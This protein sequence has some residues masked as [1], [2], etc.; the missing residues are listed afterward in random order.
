MHQ[1]AWDQIEALYS[2]SDPKTVQAFQTLKKQPVH[3]KGEGA[4]RHYCS[5]FLPYDKDKGMIYL[6]HHKKADDWIPP[7]GH[8][9]PGETPIVAAIREMKEELGTVITEEMLEPFALSGKEI[10]RPEQGCEAHY[11]VWHLVHISVQHFNFLKSEYYDANWFTFSDGLSKITKNP[12]F[13][14]IISRV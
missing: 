6:G 10:R 2:N 5:F 4:L 13:S 1:T 11:D 8:I 12:D 7:G 14:V 3:T 9:E